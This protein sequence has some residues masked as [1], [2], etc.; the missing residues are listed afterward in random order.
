L[1]FPEWFSAGPIARLHYND[2]QRERI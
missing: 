1:S 2:E